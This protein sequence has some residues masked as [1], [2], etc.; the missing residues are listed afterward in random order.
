MSLLSLTVHP[1]SRLRPLHLLVLLAVCSLWA[2]D[3]VPLTSPTGSTV[4]LTVSNTSIPINGTAQVAAAVI[5]SGGTAVH[6][7]TMVTFVGGFGTFTPPEA[8]TVRGIART[9]FTGT[10]SG[11]AKLGA[12]SGLAK[13]TEVE[14]KVGGAAAGSIAM[15][16]E[17]ATL[18]QGGGSTQIVAIVRDGS[19]NPLPIAPVNFTS[20]QG[21]LSATAAVT[22][23]NGEARVTLSTNRDTVVTANVIGTVTATTTVR[24]INAPS[25]TIALASPTTP[26]AIGVTTNFIVT[27]TTVTGGTSIQNVTVNWGDG[28]PEQNLGPISGPTNITHAFTNTGNYSVVATATDATGQR[29]TSTLSVS[30][31]RIAPTVT[32]TPATSTTTAGSTLAFAVSAA[33]GAGGPPIQNIR[34]IVSPGGQQIYS[35]P[36][37]GGFTH[38]FTTAGTH[39]L[40]ATATDTANS[41]SAG[42]AVV[43]VGNVEATLTAS[44]AGLVCNA[45]SPMTCTALAAGTN[46]TFTA[47]VTT[48]GQNGVSYAWNWGDGISPETTTARV[49]SHVYAVAGNYV[50]QVTITTS[51]GATTSQILFLRP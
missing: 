43:T 23:A 12:F 36:S 47:T 38:T 50:A 27:P 3:K 41:T 49:N 31:Q 9:V 10:G 40:T 51:S 1:V 7:G 18:P 14:V 19:G 32:I 39:T 34:V 5:E 6:D 4:T 8:T 24:I 28:S 11:T 30:L 13:A 22:D 46:V 2:C 45:L 33:P 37:G 48:A 16:S 15:R 26:P 42:T 20:D 44:G 25:V 17:P 21:N 35:G 29:S